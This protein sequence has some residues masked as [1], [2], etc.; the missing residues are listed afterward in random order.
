MLKIGIIPLNVILFPESLYPLHIF[1][2]R[3]KVLIN[4]CY[5]NNMEFGINYMNHNG[6]NEIGCTAMVSQIIKKYSNGKMDIIIQGISRYKLLNLNEKEKPYFIAEV[7]PFA[8]DDFGVD[9]NLLDETV[10]LFNKIA[11]SITS[12]KITA[13]DLTN[14]EFDYPSF[15]IAQK[16]GL[17]AEQKLSLISMR[18]ENQR[19]ETLSKKLRKIQPL[20]KKAEV[21]SN[22]VKNDGYLTLGD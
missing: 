16:A 11:S 17:T 9:K 18:S 6:I 22:I 8:D 19:L 21:I 13:L 2:D 5:T 20:I 14:M 1:E 10:R 7:E 15:Y 12:I 4:E 3:Y